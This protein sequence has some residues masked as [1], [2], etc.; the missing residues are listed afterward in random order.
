MTDYE[1]V[2]SIRKAITQISDH[3]DLALEPPRRP[4]T[5]LPTEAA[6]G[7]IRYAPK[8]MKVSPAP[9]NLDVLDARRDALL[10]LHFWARFILGE[11]RD[12]NGE[13]LTASINGTDLHALA[14]FVTTWADRLVTDHPDEA[15]DCAEEMIKHG[16]KLRGYAYPDRRDWMTLGACPV[17]LDEVCGGQVRAYPDTTRQPECAKCGTTAGTDWWMSQIAPEGSDLAT[18]REVIACVAARTYHVVTNEQLWQWA[19]RG[20]IL[21]HG[22][23]IK[24]R[25]LYSSAA[26]INWVVKGV[27][28]E[29][30]A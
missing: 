13:H 28:E 10:D 7:K 9:I 21:R 5:K 3:Y 8:A 12:I 6:E 26:V 30:A 16:N 20:N 27:K 25:T 1:L 22:K 11:V 4:A 24:G 14:T 18:A 15:A 17:I 19:S 23:D 2:G 29:V